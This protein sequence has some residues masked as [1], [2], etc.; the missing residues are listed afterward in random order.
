M[1][2][3]FK[4]FIPERIFSRQRTGYQEEQVI[5]MMRRAGVE[6]GKGLLFVQWM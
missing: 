4:S 1:R 2:E 3:S 6:L 5:P